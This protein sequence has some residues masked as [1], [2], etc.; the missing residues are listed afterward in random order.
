MPTLKRWVYR[1]VI[2]VVALA[3]AGVAVGGWIGC[4][5]GIHPAQVDSPYKPSDFDLPLEKVHFTSRDGLKLAGSFV[6]G[7]SGAT[8]VLAHGRGG[9]K[10]W[11][12][13][14]AT[15]RSQVLRL[16]KKGI[17]LRPRLRRE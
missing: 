17:E 16:A 14:H 3:V 13:P 1:V 12:L 2:L 9:Y 10:D 11:M 15:Q 7:S 6:P 5:R 4:D 8:V